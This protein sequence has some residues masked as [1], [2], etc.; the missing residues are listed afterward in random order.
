MLL[1]TPSDHIIDNEPAY[2]A[3]INQAIQWAQA[4]AL[5]T[6]GIVPTKPETGYG[7]IEHDGNDVLSFR[8]K[9]DFATA[10]SFMDRGTFLWNSGLFCFK[11]GVYLDELKR[12][13]PFSLKKPNRPGRRK[14]LAFCPLSKRSTSPPKALTTP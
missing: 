4:D 1:I 3:A 12:H 11:A 8:E 9:P 5:V 13:E 2:T 6:F 7:Y 10:Q 14:R